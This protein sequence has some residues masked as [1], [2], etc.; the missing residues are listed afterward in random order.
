MAEKK[1]NWKAKLLKITLFI[2]YNCLKFPED[3]KLQLYS[4]LYKE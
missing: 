1:G 2:L 3:E 4:Q